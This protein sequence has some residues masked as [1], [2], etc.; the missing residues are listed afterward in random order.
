MT[1]T[2]APAVERRTRSR[3]NLDALVQSRTQTLSLLTQLAGQQP[4]TPDLETEKALRKFCQA[5]IDYT[6]SAHFQ[7][8]RYLADKRERRRSVRDAADKAYPK[9]I[10]TTDIILRFNDKYEAISLDNG[11]EYLASDLSRLGECLAE[12]IS[13]EDSIIEAMG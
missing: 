1:T 12:R 4:F 10:E 13:L 9:I 3:E 5:L 2:E 8:Y 7:L 6:A 11:L